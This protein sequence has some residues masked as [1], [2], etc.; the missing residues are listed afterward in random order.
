MLLALTELLGICRPDLREVG[1]RSLAHLRDYGMVLMN[2][3]QVHLQ[4]CQLL[5][6]L[7][8]RER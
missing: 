2:L 5:L 4:L 6:H 7:R 3:L 1:L 8:I